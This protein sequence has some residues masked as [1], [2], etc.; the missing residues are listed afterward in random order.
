MGEAKCRSGCT[1]TVHCPI[2]VGL[3]TAPDILLVSLKKYS[4]LRYRRMGQIRG[5]HG[6]AVVSLVFPDILLLAPLIFQ[7]PETYM[8]SCLYPTLHGVRVQCKEGTGILWESRGLGYVWSTIYIDNTFC[9][10]KTK[11]RK[12]YK[13]LVSGAMQKIE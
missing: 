6:L 9:F 4:L 3:R 13:I 11:D 1:C 12:S 2:L 5:F 10:H 7:G 8:S